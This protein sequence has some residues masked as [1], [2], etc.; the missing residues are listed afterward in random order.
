MYFQQGFVDFYNQ[1]KNHDD[2]PWAVSGLVKYGAIGV[3]GAMAIGALLQRTWNVP[4]WGSCCCFLLLLH[5]FSERNS[6]FKE[7][8]GLLHK[9]KK[10]LWVKLQ[11]RCVCLTLD[12][13]EDDSYIYIQISWKNGNVYDCVVRK[14]IQVLARLLPRDIS[15][16]AWSKWYQI[17]ICLMKIL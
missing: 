17:C 1:G 16:S 5:R 13:T 8:Y 3:L 2:S 11:K 4:I 6:D 10:Y 12:S 7:K 15:L 9:R 14:F